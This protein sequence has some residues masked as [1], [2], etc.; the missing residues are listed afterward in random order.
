MLQ[1]TENIVISRKLKKINQNN[2]KCYAVFLS[3]L[4]IWLGMPARQ[5]QEG[6]LEQKL[7]NS[8]INKNQLRQY[9]MLQGF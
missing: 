2:Y 1:L 8:S 4:C 7:K 6:Q 5:P 3:F 9:E